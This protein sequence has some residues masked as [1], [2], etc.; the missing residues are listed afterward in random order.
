MHRRME[1][2]QH[3]TRNVEA[4]L[5]MANRQLVQVKAQRNLLQRQRDDQVHRVAGD[6]AD[7]YIRHSDQLALQAIANLS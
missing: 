2:A 6:K 3:K 4:K 5:E 1:D 7:A